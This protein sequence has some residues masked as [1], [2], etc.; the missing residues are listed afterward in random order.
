MEET[1]N[2]DR[3]TLVFDLESGPRAIIDRV[4]FD[5]LDPLDGKTFLAQPAV[6]KGQPYDADAILRELQRYEDNLRARGYYEARAVH[7]VEFTPEGTAAVTVAVER[8]PRVSVA[9]A[10][11]PLPEA[12]RERLV[13]VRAEGS[14]DEDLLEDAS[15]A[16]EDYLHARGYSDAV[17]DYSR[18]ERDGELT[19]TFIVKRGR[20]HVVDAVR[21]NGNMAVTDAEL[22]QLRTVEAGRAVRAGDARCRR[23]GDSQ[24]LSLA[25]LH[26]GN[27]RADSCRAARRQRSAARPTISA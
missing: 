25:R 24:R 17:A 15:R 11:D 13:P 18:D 6:R 22:L 12:E 27:G 8:G 19:I 20:R 2:P 16:I 14:A 23:R 9:F 3:A 10:G 21:L 7:T 4:E 5:Q 26:A 1:H